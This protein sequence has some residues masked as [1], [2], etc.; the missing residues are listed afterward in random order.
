ME[1]N[2]TVLPELSGERIDKFV[3]ANVEELSR[4]AA[5]ALIDGGGVTVNGKSIAKNYKTRNGDEITVI[6]PEP[7]ELETAPENIPLDIV[8]EDGD[9]LVVN[10]PKGMVV[11]PAPG[12]YSGTLV[13]ALL[14]HCRDSLSGINGVLRP[15]IVHRIDKDTSGLL[16]VA[17][18]DKAHIGLAEQIKEHS[19]TREY[20]AVVYGKLKDPTGTVDAPIGRHK[21]DRKKMCVTPNNSKH[22]VTHYR[23]IDYN[24]GFSHAALKLETGRTHQIRVHMAYIGHPVAGDSVYGP[25]KVIMSL[26]GQCLHAKKIGFVHPITGEELFFDSQLPEYFR[27]FLAKYNIM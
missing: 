12:N 9:L 5:A 15:G 27:E 1:Y 2:F 26:N 13:N 20:E 6:V 8:Y 21:T 4:S 14:Y 3:S 22:A 7:K 24:N 19:F 16:I 18:S 11:H 10:K 25:S 23:V 17:K